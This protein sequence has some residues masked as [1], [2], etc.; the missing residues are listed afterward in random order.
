M[1]PIDKIEVRV[2]NPEVIH[3]LNKERLISQE[4]FELDGSLFFVEVL[5]V[6]PSEEYLVCYC[7]PISKDGKKFLRNKEYFTLL[8][9]ED[10]GC[11]PI[12]C[13]CCG[14]TRD[15]SHDFVFFSEIIWMEEYGFVKIV[16]K[17]VDTWNDTVQR[18][19]FDRELYEKEKKL[20]KQER[21]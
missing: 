4:T 14:E 1:N 13:K 6:S 3:K 20:R 8:K 10:T 19:Y 12:V 2:S 15:S 16:F 7:Y 11:V 17:D 21:S 5:S 18:I 9:K